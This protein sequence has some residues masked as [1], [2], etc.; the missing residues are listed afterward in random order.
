MLIL[1]CLDVFFLFLGESYT[2]QT[3]ISDYN[4]KKKS[5]VDPESFIR[6][7]GVQV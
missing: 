1:S 3:E 6:G 2:D 7:I 5:C 4:V